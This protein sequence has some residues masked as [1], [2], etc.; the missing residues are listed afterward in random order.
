MKA[1]I[2]HGYNIVGDGTPAA[3]IPIL[4]SKHEDELPNTIKNTP[5]AMFVD[6]AYP[7][8]WKNYSE[9][10]GY[11]TMLAEDWPNIG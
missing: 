9:K 2:L 1:N 10:L 4:T 5:N 3:L 6:E 7:F 11:A 8:I